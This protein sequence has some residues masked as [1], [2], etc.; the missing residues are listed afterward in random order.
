MSNKQ[1]LVVDTQIVGH[2]VLWLTLVA[3]TFLADGFTVT[4]LVNHDLAEVKQK[5]LELDT[6]LL[7]QVN[8][9]PS[10]LSKKTGAKQYLATI[11]QIAREINANEVFFDNFDTIASKLFRNSVFGFKP[12]N[13]LKGIVSMVY[14]RPRPLDKRQR[15]F[16][17][18]LKKLGLKKVIASGLFKQIFLL[19]PFL[20]E[21][22]NNELLHT[23]VNYLP[24]PWLCD[25]NIAKSPAEFDYN[26]ITGKKVI[27][28]YGVGDARK[29]TQLLLQALSIT[30]SS[31]EIVLCIAGVQK[32]QE[33]VKLIEQLKSKLNIIL[34]NRY[35]A[36]SEEDFLFKHA[37]FIA[38]PYISHY[39]SSNILSKAAFYTKPVVAS[40]Y[41]LIGKLV[42]KYELGLTFTNNNAESLAAVIDK[43]MN[44]KTLEI[45]DNL[46]N[47]AARCSYSAFQH[48]ILSTVAR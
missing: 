23:K 3:K 9:I 30:K 17:N 14:H 31:S 45:E 43:I 22:C 7:D 40:D 38:I 5:I 6:T 29:G 34:I 46:T 18:Y 10:D 32:N 33:L 26:I 20:V 25:K 16:G 48:S 36:Q 19:N 13:Y 41:D 12:D 4:L 11:A 47:Y 28:Q 15:G 1:V 39:G 37:D 8:L 44:L 42:N 2:H 27:L 21:E 35:I 24:D